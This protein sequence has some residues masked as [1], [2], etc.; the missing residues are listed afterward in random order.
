MDSLDSK[1]VENL[2]DARKFMEE[3][4]PLFPQRRCQHSA[5]FL[6]EVFGFEEV[7]GKHVVFDLWHA[8]NYYFVNDKYID[9]TL[10]QFGN[11][12]SVMVLDS[13]EDLLIE[14]KH[15][16]EH[17]NS[18]KTEDLCDVDLPYLIEKFKKE[19][20]RVF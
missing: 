6:K 15:M 2:N 1:L 7:G 19:Y 13:N 3:N 12:A 9:L 10:D 20:L 17:I 11:Y 8:W 4:I 16:T 14:K 5:R 18:V